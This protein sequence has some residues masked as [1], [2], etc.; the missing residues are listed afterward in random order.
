[1]EYRFSKYFLF[2]GNL[3]KMGWDLIL[4]V[5]KAFINRSIPIAG[6]SREIPKGISQKAA[7]ESE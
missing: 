6:K 1:M 7:G 2:M 5:S 4:V 3:L